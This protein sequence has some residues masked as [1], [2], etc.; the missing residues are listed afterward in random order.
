MTPKLVPLIYHST[1]QFYLF[2]ASAFSKLKLIQLKLTVPSFV[3]FFIDI[4]ATC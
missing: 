4:T 3:L 1:I 2:F